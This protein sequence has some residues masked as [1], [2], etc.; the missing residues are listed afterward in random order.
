MLKHRH[1]ILFLLIILALLFSGGCANENLLSVKP[2]ASKDTTTT[3]T[4]SLTEEEKIQV[5]ALMQ[6]FAKDTTFRDN[7]SFDTIYLDNRTR[8]TMIGG[9]VDSPLPRRRVPD[10]IYRTLK[11]NLGINIIPS[12]S[13]DEVVDSKNNV[14]GNGVH[15]TVTIVV[16][17][18][19]R[20]Y[21]GAT[22]Y[23]GDLG[24]IYITYEVKQVEPEIILMPVSNA[25]S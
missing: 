13:R 14:I 20:R 19:G 17:K 2:K 25:V 4:M 9:F 5:Y 7:P 24:A 21:V 8:D 16:S 18:N 3:S 1:S 23:R 6:M 10:L 12:V 22:I 11:E 15:M